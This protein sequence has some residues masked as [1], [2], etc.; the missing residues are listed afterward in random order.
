MKPAKSL[1]GN[2]FPFANRL[3]SGEEGIVIAR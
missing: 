3:G 2:D 1:D